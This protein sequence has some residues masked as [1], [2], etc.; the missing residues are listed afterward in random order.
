MRPKHVGN[1]PPFKIPPPLTDYT[2]I[3]I[4]LQDTHDKLM[5]STAA[6]IF[7]PPQKTGFIVSVHRLININLLTLVQ[8]GL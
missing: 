1:P 8:A 5:H 2:T 3:S 7:C 6:V 4:L